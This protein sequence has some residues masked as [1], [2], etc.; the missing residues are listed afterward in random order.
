M[1]ILLSQTGKGE[2]SSR[3]QLLTKLFQKIGGGERERTFEEFCTH[4]RFGRRI[5]HELFLS[6]CSFFAFLLLM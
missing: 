2:R 4:T 5:I 6:P 3:F 1:F